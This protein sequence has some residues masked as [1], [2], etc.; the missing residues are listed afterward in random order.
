VSSDRK[1]TRD[2]LEGALRV[3]HKKYGKDSVRYLGE[4]SKDYFIE[5][6]SSGL[7][8][9]DDMLEGGLPKSRIIQMWGPEG[10][11]KTTVAVELAKAAGFCAYI[12]GEGMLDEERIIGFGI[13]KN[14]FMYQRPEYGEEMVE[15][16]IEFT[17]ASVPLIVMDSVPTMVPKNFMEKEIGKDPV[18]IIPRLLSQQL[19]PR[20]IPALKDSNSTVLFINQIREKVGILFGDPFDFPGGR[21]LKHYLS[22]NIRLARKQ[23]YGPKKNRIGMLIGCQVTKSKVCNPFRECELVLSFKEGFVSHKEMRAMLKAARINEEGDD[24]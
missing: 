12:D 22:V 14:R 8:D 7:D 9:F 23:W 3:I 17:K 16:I 5:R 10:V 11:G 1:F 20:L 15:S 18:A 24:D 13:K 6:W 4:A 19:F 21:A 2:K